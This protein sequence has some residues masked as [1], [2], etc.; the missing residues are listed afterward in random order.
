MDILTQGLLGAV[1]AQTGAQRNE[2]RI[3]TGVGFASGLL[4]DVD[5][6][7]RSST[8]PLLTLEYHRH[9]THSLVFIPIGALI[10]ALILWPIVRKRL[11]FARLYLYALLGYS[12]SGAL[13]AC[14]SY[15]THLLWPF[16]QEPIALHLISIID[17]V[18]TLILL[19][20]M[21][22]SVK[23]NTRIA[24]QLGLALAGVY[25]LCGWAQNQRAVPVIEAMA[26]ERGHNIE[27][28]V[29]KPT[30]GNLLLWRSIYQT[31]GRLYVDSV[32]V[33]LISESRVYQGDSVALFKLERDLPDL[34]PSSVLYKDIQRFI[35]FAD[36]F[37]AIDPDRPN[38]LTDIR[39][40]NVPNSI[41]PLWG[42]ELDMN[43]PEQHANYNFYRDL[44]KENRQRFLSMLFNKK[45]VRA[46]SKIN[47]H[48]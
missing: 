43:K 22:V 48:F 6:L 23:K 44:S 4:A 24:A 31:N 17:P 26:V 9:F 29:V 34:S 30:L 11:G 32:R 21:V 41:K 35:K 42:I 18:F 16:M 3:A 46:A 2:T 33:G 40:S 19:I 7:I 28:L 39:Y 38:V 10:A 8:D 25:M 15:G 20:A 14:T 27:R 12:L 13:D 47:S 37:A 1:L 5:A 45:E 36:G